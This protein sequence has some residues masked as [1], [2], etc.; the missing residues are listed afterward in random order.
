MKKYTFKEVDDLLQIAGF[1]TYNLSPFATPRPY[2]CY[3][4]PGTNSFSGHLYTDQ[5]KDFILRHIF[6]EC[7]KVGKIQLRQELHHLISNINYE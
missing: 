6:N 1:M 3:T 5:T 7:K 2:I 4:H